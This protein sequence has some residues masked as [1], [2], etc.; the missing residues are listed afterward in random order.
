MFN[1]LA[2]ARES[3]ICPEMLDD[4]KPINAVATPD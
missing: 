3:G 1:H 2:P 4:P